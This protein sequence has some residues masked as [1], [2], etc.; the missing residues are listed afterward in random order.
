MYFST[1]ALS[2]LITLSLGSFENPKVLGKYPC[3]VSI[4][5]EKLP[6]PLSLIPDTLPFLMVFPSTSLNNLT[7]PT[8]FKAL[9]AISPCTYLASFSSPV[10]SNSICSPRASPSG[11][12]FKSFVPLSTIPMFPATLKNSWSS[13]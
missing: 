2:I 13:A 1:C 5:I 3:G 6:S 4:I 9:T 11:P 7:I 12:F 10:F 8:S